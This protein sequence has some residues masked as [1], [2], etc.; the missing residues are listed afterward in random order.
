MTIIS[1]QE[2][3]KSY[4]RNKAV[5]RVSF[6]I[7]QDTF[8]GVIGR[9]GAGKS[10]LLKLISGLISPSEG[11]LHVFGREP[12]N[13]L[14]VSANTVLIDE[15]MSFPSVMSLTDILKTGQ[16]FFPRW[17]H[18]L[19]TKLLNYFEIDPHSRHH[20]LSKGKRSTFHA[21]FGIASRS[22]LTIFDEPVSG[23][24][25]QVRSDFYRAL[26]KDY[27]KEPRTILFSSHHL[28]E[29]EDLL[30]DLLLLDEG[31]IKLHKPVDEVR[32]MVY[33]VSGETEAVSEHLSN[34]S[35]LHEFEPAPNYKTAAVLSSSVTENEK[36]RWNQNGLKV[37]Y[38]SPSEVCRY[39]TT[40]EKGGIDS[41]FDK[42]QSMGD[43]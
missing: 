19:A 10:T 26:L 27:L 8:T 24:D 43:Y 12:F 29:A 9:N 41:V 11:E 14:H 7:K 3:T 5:N 25:E 21:I 13:N 20:E 23:M 15:H 18:H 38:A 32:E 1:G 31:E 40:T 30:E 28:S 36:S 33:H 16:M 6:R 39:L 34:C 4:S 2:L 35:V 22:S 37:S 17:D 42:R